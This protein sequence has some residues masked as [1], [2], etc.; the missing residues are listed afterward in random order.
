MPCVVY[1]EWRNYV[2]YAE[3][4]YTECCVTECHY[5]V[6]IILNVVAPSGAHYGNRPTRKY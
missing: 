1:A 4:R 6:C 2:D 3:C 5:A